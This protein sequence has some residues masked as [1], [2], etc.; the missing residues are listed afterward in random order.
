MLKNLQSEDVEAILL[1]DSDLADFILENLRSS[2][3]SIGFSKLFLDELLS[4]LGTLDVNVFGEKWKRELQEKYS[5]GF[6]QDLVPKYFSDYVVPMTPSASKIV[7][8]GCGTGILDK[9]YAEDGR[10]G[11]VIGIDINR[12]PEWAIFQNEKIRFDV[13]KEDTFTSFL[14]IEKPDSIVLTWALHHMEYDEQERYL[15]YIYE[16]LKSG[17]R[18]VILE[19]SYSTLFSP[20]N[21][22]DKYGKFMEWN[23]EQRKKIMS[24]YD[25]VANRV[26]A[27]REQEPIPCTYRTLEEWG[28]VLEKSGF[29]IVIQKFIGFPSNRDIN[30]PQSLIVVE[31]K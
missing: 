21:G 18:V 12:Y 4:S 27:Q 24:V 11:T 8:V 26:L 19:D 22:A 7:D 25:W 14:N 15:G 16:N 30:T 20:E 2:L 17:A 1:S 28:D 31:K 10:F 5:T 13:I 3:S 23:I 29:M 6:F 9:L